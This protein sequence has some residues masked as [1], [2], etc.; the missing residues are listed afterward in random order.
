[1]F[2]SLMAPVLGSMHWFVIGLLVLA[3]VFFIW[4]FV[5]PGFR[6][7]REL[8]KAH[9]ALSALKTQ[10]PVLDL[11]RVA[12]EAMGS[13]QLQH[14][15]AEYRDTLHEQ[16]Q[17]DE[18]G[19]LQVVR[20][21]ATALSQGFFTEQALVDGPLRTEFYKHLPGMLTGLGIIGTFS[22]LIL[23]LQTF[24]VV[25]D[26]NVVRQSLATLIQSVGQAFIVSGAAIVLAM[27][28]T[29]WEK[30]S[31]N[32]LYTRVEAL[33]GLIDS[34]YDAGAGEEYLQRLVEASETSATQ[35]LQMKESLV[36]DLKQVL[37]ELTQQQIAT[38]TATSQQL[39]QSIATSLAEGLTEPLNRISDA[40]Q[41][42]GGNQGDAV[43]KM[44]TDVLSGFSAQMESM[45]GGQLRGMNE[46]LQQ[47]A[48]TIA[49]ASQR[50]ED[51]AGRIE[52]AGTGAA[53]GMAK[54]MEEL[55]AQMR[56]RQAEADAQMSGFIE[57]MQQTVNKGQSDTAELTLGMMKELSATTSELV[58]GL[59]RQSQDAQAS[60]AELQVQQAA[61]ADK[62]LSAQ[63][64]QVADLV[65]A[66]DEA[67]QAMRSS[68]DSLVTSTN[69]N[70]DRMGVGAERLSG[71]SVRL[72]DKLDAVTQV[73]AGIDSSAGQ[74][75][76]ASGSVSA[77][78]NAA[79]TVISD[80][81][82]VRDALASLVSDLRGTVEAAK[83]EAGFTNQLLDGLQVASQRLTDAQRTAEHYLEQVSEVL[84]QAHSDFAMQ[85]QA[86]LRSSNSA[87]HQELSQA[88]NYLK[89]AIQDLGDVV[90]Q[91]PS[92][93]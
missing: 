54:R 84:G 36:T 51:L 90:D 7:A 12:T 46:M 6:V 10:G 43:N 93:A 33:C 26:A 65:D 23:G 3:A 2:A 22:G 70:V 49:T 79:A 64:D 39:G 56:D 73:V 45:F 37:T 71:A 15:W 27:A 76:Q 50:F 81:R 83:R 44:L 48:S 86:T 5:R 59:Q 41:T 67:A 13:R 87:F 34:L 68:V 75:V 60:H 9:Q 47:T 18:F 14:C 85:V 21:R 77:A 61:R 29:W 80:Q 91:L 58:A 66:V 31:I 88:V 16:K 1:M 69:T 35:A 82:T 30:R 19:S 92:R 57:K 72:A 55:M 42:V 78:L 89:G 20:L 40:V 62:L 28:G 52:Q 17:P 38:M 8:T 25:D 32:I 74:L 24:Q 53:D 4:Q 11:E 63:A